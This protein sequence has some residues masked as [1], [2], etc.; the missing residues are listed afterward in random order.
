MNQTTSVFMRAKG[1]LDRV[2]FFVGAVMSWPAWVPLILVGSVVGLWFHLSDLVMLLL[3]IQTS[4]DAAATKTLQSHV[5]LVDDLKD[6]Q[7]HQQISDSSAIVVEVRRQNDLLI[8]LMMQAQRRDQLSAKRDKMTLAALE[9][10]NDLLEYLR[11]EV[12]RHEHTRKTPAS[13][14]GKRTTHGRRDRKKS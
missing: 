12:L 3:T 11:E 4:V 13:S 8:D 7:L 2:A 9:A 1:M 10:R 5:R 14:R 6:Q